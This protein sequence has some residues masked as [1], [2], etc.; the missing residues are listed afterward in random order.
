MAHNILGTLGIGNDENLVTGV[1]T[2]KSNI[3]SPPSCT[4]NT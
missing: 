4:E 1:M 3:S 2:D